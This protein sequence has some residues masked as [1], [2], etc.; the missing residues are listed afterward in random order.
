M[1]RP[2][3]LVLRL[4]QLVDHTDDRKWLCELDP[5]DSNGER[6]F[7]VDINIDIDDQN[8]P[9]ASTFESGVTKLDGDSIY[10]H[11]HHAYVHG[12]PSFQ[13][14]GLVKQ[15]RDER[16]LQVVE[17]NKT[18]LVLRAVAADAET[19][20]SN[21]QLALKIFGV[22]GQDDFNLSSGYDECSYGKLQFAPTPL[23]QD[24][25]LTV[26]I[27]DFVQNS[28]TDVIRD[29]MLDKA[30]SELGVT[31][32]QSIADYTMVCIPPGTGNGWVAY[33]FVNQWLSV[34]ND[35][36]CTSPSAQIHEIGHNI[37][38]FLSLRHPF[39]SHEHKIIFLTMISTLI[40]SSFQVWAI[41]KIFFDLM[42]DT[43]E[44]PNSRIFIPVTHIH[45]IHSL[46]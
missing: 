16:H 4:T 24:G 2:C 25:V 23:I 43:E 35:E 9:A 46:V 10:L 39:A 8:D 38:E 3:T 27:S 6:G 45:M 36:W 44:N 42:N 29:A 19:T 28:D 18:V 37:G 34:Y 20:S 1:T 21:E 33:A 22:G 5:A 17:G 12:S 40:I 30:R 13:N 31:D 32:L 11:G 41:G 26:T 14:E 7:F 15:T